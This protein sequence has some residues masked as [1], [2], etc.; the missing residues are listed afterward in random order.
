MVYD[1]I[2]ADMVRNKNLKPI[3]TELFVRGKKLHI[4][5]FSISQSYSKCLKV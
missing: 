3:V 1:D 2:L 4:S 5:I